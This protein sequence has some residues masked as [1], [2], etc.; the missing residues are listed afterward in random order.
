MYS[1]SRAF[2]EVVKSGGDSDTIALSSGRRRSLGRQRQALASMNSKKKKKKKE[3]KKKGKRNSSRGNIVSTSPTAAHLVD[4]TMSSRTQKVNQSLIH[5][6]NKSKLVAIDAYGADEEGSEYMRDALESNSNSSGSSNNYL[7][8]ISS[9]NLIEINSNSEGIVVLDDNDF[10]YD[11][12][13]LS[14]STAEE[15]E[16]IVARSHTTRCIDF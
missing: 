12:R 9:S 1:W 6:N 11:C 3:E 5:L 10:N 4:T 2:W 16:E 13:G 14:S 7:F 8:P 15:K